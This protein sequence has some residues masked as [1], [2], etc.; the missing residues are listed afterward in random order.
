MEVGFPS[1]PPKSGAVEVA[2]Q[3]LQEQIFDQSGG[4]ALQQTNGS[5]E[6]K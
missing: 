3:L 4:K 6:I 5:L 2:D 1:A